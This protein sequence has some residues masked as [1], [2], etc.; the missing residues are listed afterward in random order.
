M[1]MS[2]TSYAASIYLRYTLQLIVNKGI[3]DKQRE[4][5]L[6]TLHRL[7]PDFCLPW[8]VRSRLQLDQTSL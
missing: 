8:P 1:K 4:M 5:T 6:M 3:L 7:L 2:I